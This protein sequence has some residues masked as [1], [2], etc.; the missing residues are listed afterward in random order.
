MV[1]LT[2]N[3]IDFF[4]GMTL[5]FCFFLIWCYQQNENATMWI[6]TGVHGTYGILWCTKSFYYPDKSF[7]VEATPF[8]IVATTIVLLGYWLAPYIIAA[9]EVIKLL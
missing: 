4:K 7:D 3:V 2:S 8:M 5:P 1:L 9:Y 6:Y